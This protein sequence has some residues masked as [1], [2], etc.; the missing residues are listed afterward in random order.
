MR[1][2]I[3]AP[4]ERAYHSA[5]EY[6]REHYD[7]AIRVTLPSRHLISVDDLTE[8]AIHDLEGLGAT[9]DEDFRYGMDIGNRMSFG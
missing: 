4:D 6:V 7:E 8:S 2:R 3:L 5:L 9:V 1:Y